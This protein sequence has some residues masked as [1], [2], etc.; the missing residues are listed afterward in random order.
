MA[1]EKKVWARTRSVE[2]LGDGRYR[3]QWL[4]ENGSALVSMELLISGEAPEATID[5]NFNMMRQNNMELF[6]EPAEEAE[7]MMEMD[8]G[9][10]V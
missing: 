1:E 8:N 3:L 5:A 2:N 4:D 10:T 7:I 9:E 6:V